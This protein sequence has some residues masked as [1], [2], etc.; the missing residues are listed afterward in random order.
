MDLDCDDCECCEIVLDLL[1]GCV[2][3][4][5]CWLKNNTTKNE[6]NWLINFY[7]VILCMF[8]FA[9]IFVIGTVW[10]VGRVTN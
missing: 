3:G 1:D 10:I 7:C 9:L 2:I 5:C 6:G 4:K 8:V